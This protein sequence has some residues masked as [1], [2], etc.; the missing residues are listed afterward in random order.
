MQ[1]LNLQSLRFFPIIVAVGLAGVAPQ[2]HATEEFAAKVAPL[3]ARRCLQCHNPADRKGG[4]DLTESKAAQAGGESGKVLVAGKPDDS[5]LWLKV[6]ENE[7]PPKKPLSKDE[8]ATLRAWITSGAHWGTGPIDRFQYTTDDRAGYDWWSLQPI[9]R[10]EPPKTADENWPRNAID[11]FVLSKL[12]SKSLS[13]APLAD[14]HTQIRRLSFDLLG[15]PPDPAELSAFVADAS[16][17]AYARLVDRMLRSPHYGERWARH[18]LDVVRFG[19]SQGFERDKHRPDSWHYRDWVIEALNNDMPFD[20][21]VRLQLAGDVLAPNDPTAVIATGFLVAGPWDEVGQTQQSEA[22]KAVVRADELEDLAAGVGQGFLGLTVNCARCHDHKFDPITAVDYYRFISCLS[23]IRHGDRESLSKTGQA[24]ADARRDALKPRLD[25]LLMELQAVDAPARNRVIAAKNVKPRPVV[26][27]PRPIARWDFT[28]GLEDQIGKAHCK[29]HGAARRDATGLILDGKDGYAASEPLEPRLYGKTLEAWV[30]LTDL[31][32]KGGGVLSI[33]SLDGNIFDAIVFGEREPGRWMAGSNGY[34]RYKSFD[35]PEETEANQRFVQLAIVYRVDFGVQCFRD[36]KPYGS[37]Y[38]APAVQSFDGGKSQAVFGLRH[39]PVG[40]GKMLAGTIA[41]AQ[42]YDVALAPEQVAKSAGAT[43]DEPTD[44]EVLAQLT[45]AERA[46]R[47]R[48]LR[49]ISQLRMKQG[50]LSGGPA[51]AVSPQQPP[52]TKV[53]HRGN[54]GKTGG[55]VKPGG[56]AVVRAADPEFQLPADAPEAQRRLQLARWITDPNNPLTARV[57]VNRLWH[58]HFGVGLVDTPNDFG[59]NGGRPSHP[60]LLD[61]LT[62]ELI[63]NRWSLKQ[64]HRAIVMSATYRQSSRHDPRAA[65]VDADNRLLWRKSPMRLEAESLRDAMLS[66]AAAL[67]PTMGGQGFQDYRT[68]TSNTQFYEQIDP[69]GFAFQRRSIYRTWIRS[70]R[71]KFLDVFDCPDPSTA[72]PK[73]AVT[74]TPLQALSL[75]NNSFVLRTANRFAD[76]LRE[77]CGD[78][79]ARQLLR[80]YELAYARTPDDEELRQVQPFI[81]QHGLPAFCR[82]IFNSNEFLYV[83]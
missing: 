57:I 44:D 50:L 18:W 67:N 7:M 39:S 48:L 63:C 41:R 75:L 54:P 20:E 38:E 9:R 33:Q 52:V 76:R 74:T 82:V 27:V 34:Q 78:D 61:W 23:G 83:D 21:F 46:R 62:S 60:E 65:K 45:F 17:E 58:Y 80:A 71:N 30:K 5:P 55:M 6:N 77:E 72:T 28:K 47:N 22:M 49:D 4:L 66:V 19:E 12:E 32:Q 2:G 43:P 73:R 81:A 10:P 70:G 31:G 53:Q 37:V 11:R 3:L 79:P 16:P 1:V 42:L 29:L 24:T 8:K 69:V 40:G 25:K 64:L 15:L 35:A 26:A 51:Y 59:F 68:F 14:K 13:P 36:G 56:I